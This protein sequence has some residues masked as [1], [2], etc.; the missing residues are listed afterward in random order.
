MI[1]LRHIFVFTV[2]V[3]LSLYSA[4]VLALG[5]ETQK[6]RQVV[7]VGYPMQKGF[8][9]V[10]E[11][12]NLIG[13]TYEYLQEIAQYNGWRYEFVQIPGNP[14]ESLEILL[15]MLEQGE[16]DLIGGMNYS[17]ALAM[18][19]NY[20]GYSYGTVYTV[21]YVRN[22]NNKD[23]SSGEQMQMTIAVPDHEERIAELNQ[24]CKV[25][26]IEPTLL[27]CQSDKEMLQALADGRADAMLNISTNNMEGV[28]QIAKFA[29]RPY[30]FL[31]SKKK[32][33]LEQQLNAAILNINQAD[34]LFELSLQEKY[35]GMKSRSLILTS[36][37]KNYI[38]QSKILKV[39][40]LLDSPPI[41]FEVKGEVRGIAID[42]LEYITAKTGLK[43]EIVPINSKEEMESKIRSHEIDLI[44]GVNYDY[45]YTQS[46]EVALTRP[47]LEAPYFMLIN[48]SF[49]EKDLTGSRLA[50]PKSF[51]YQGRFLSR[52]IWYETI[53]ECLEAV[54]NGKADYTYADGYLVQYYMGQGYFSNI[55]LVPLASI[56]HKICFGV[57][58][59]IERPLLS[60]LNKVFVSISPE[61]IQTIIYKNTINEKGLSLLGLIKA[62]A[63]ESI[64]IISGLLLCVIGGLAF[65]L[66]IYTKMNRKIAMDLK[67]HFQVY[68]LTSERF[69]EYDYQTET[70]MVSNGN[71][72]P[73]QGILT[74]YSIQDCKKTETEEKR[75]ERERFLGV[76]F[77][78]RDGVEEIY[79]LCA[80]GKYHWL[81]MYMKTI[82]DKAKKPVYTVGKVLR[83]DNER[84]E[85][86]KLL[87]KAQRDSLTHLLNADTCRKAIIDD[88]DRLKKKEH[89]ILF[90]IDID[91]FKHINDTF[92]HLQGDQILC[93]VA[94][95]LLSS[96]RV[97]DIVGRPGGDEFLVYIK[98]IRDLHAIKQK[99]NIVCAML[100]G[101]QLPNQQHITVSIGIHIASAGESYRFIYQQADKALYEVK[102][103]GRDGY[104]FSDSS[105]V[106]NDK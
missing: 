100:R 106:R 4:S 105:C 28:R 53:Q 33:Q 10:D 35:F 61:E 66:K 8:T 18:K 52:P 89:S 15:G 74:Q 27:H 64:L 79:T 19:F 14:S 95:V 57:V 26:G 93:Q 6:G 94:Q 55:S 84:E 49:L 9:E 36:E 17:E 13:Y 101:I 46:E 43:F 23:Y 102:E 41:H 70:I 73:S 98:Q 11:H 91:K 75:I 5:A 88:L 29:P 77:A 39:G 47:F 80:D 30:Y 22:D 16:I 31:T 103:K 38:N 20:A 51:N 25:T 54:N 58:E 85:K 50:L 42:L 21:L 83:I 12:G 69:F 86:I 72:N 2:T 82:Y 59:P 44:A 87:E 67:K 24:Y 60:I 34:S 56:V 71:T 81:R 99:C 63:I 32:P 48:Q 90:L 92:G 104:L 1:R 96:F 65:G 37:E 68:E 97:D 3:I 62:N 7:R 78:Q 40:V 45:E 76:V